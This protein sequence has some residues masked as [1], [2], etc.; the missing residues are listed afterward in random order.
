MKEERPGGLKLKVRLE[1]K[2]ARSPSR[3]A[4][5]VC[6]SLLFMTFSIPGRTVC[7]VVGHNN[8][9]ARARSCFLVAA[10]RAV[11]VPVRCSLARRLLYASSGLPA[12]YLIR[13]LRSKMFACSRARALML[14]SF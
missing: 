12:C 1:K 13:C 9:H 6:S 5:R 7:F 3:Q 11:G 14:G 4:G 8:S 2:E 10:R